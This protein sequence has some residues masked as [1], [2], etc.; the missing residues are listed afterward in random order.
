VGALLDTLAVE[1][2]EGLRLGYVEIA[3]ASGTVLAR[4]GG[5]DDALEELP[6]TAYGARVGSLRW[7]RRPL[8]DTDRRLLVDLANQLGSV[9]HAGGLLASVR[10]AQ[11]HLVMAREEERRRLRRD[12]HDG[13]GPA[14]AALALEVDTLRNRWG[15]TGADS[16]LLDLRAGIQ[17]T[18]LDVRRI[19]EGLRPAA[20]D[21]LGLV[22]AVRQLAGRWG[23][24]LDVV[25]D[26]DELPRLPAAVEV[27]A[28]RIVQEAL[29]NA[30]RHSGASH[31]RVSLAIAEQELDVAVVDDGTG[32]VRPRVG[33]VGLAS[34]RERTEEIGGTFSLRSDPGCGT[35]IRARLPLG[36][37]AL[38]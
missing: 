10:A 9:V 37:G 14:L 20:L 28:Y 13:L 12:L 1:L 21:D 33:G 19:V 4:H 34:M 11:E 18:V 8:R 36:S 23:G 5:P 3:D 27:G 15:D 24:G 6:L 32:E 2:A 31:A 38:Q 16:G 25:V 29:T 30:V 26:G 17:D 22:E 7:S 35:T